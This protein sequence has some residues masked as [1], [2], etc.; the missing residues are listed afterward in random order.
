MATPAGKVITGYSRS[1]R[2][3]YGTAVGSQYR[4]D[5]ASRHTRATARKA[6]LLD[7]LLTQAAQ[8]REATGV[9]VFEETAVKDIMA[10]KGAIYDEKTRI[11][12]EAGSMERYRELL[13]DEAPLDSRFIKAL[14]KALKERA[15]AKSV[16]V[17]LAAD[18]EAEVDAL[19]AEIMGLLGGLKMG[20]G[21]RRRRTSRRHRMRKS[22]RSK[23]HCRH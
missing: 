2:P 21:A 15:P 8:V 1:G 18:E 9:D 6:S 19:D 3:I 14:S 16:I 12:N 4:S 7:K 5:V 17:G 20:G 13:R 22:G 23:S 10:A 11:E